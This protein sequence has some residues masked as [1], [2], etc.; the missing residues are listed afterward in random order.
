MPFKVTY[1]KPADD[2]DEQAMSTGD[3]DALQAEYSSTSNDA[4]AVVDPKLLLPL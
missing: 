1:G 2:H 4:Q 3:H